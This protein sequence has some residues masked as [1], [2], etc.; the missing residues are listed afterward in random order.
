MK[1][2]GF[3]AHVVGYTSSSAEGFQSAQYAQHS[4]DH[5]KFLVAPT[6][7]FVMPTLAEHGLLE[8]GLTRSLTGDCGYTLFQVVPTTSRHRDGD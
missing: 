5:L 2:T 3:N 8:H 1:H 4:T 7:G 6:V